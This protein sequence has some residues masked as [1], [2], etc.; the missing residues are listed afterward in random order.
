MKPKCLWCN[1]EMVP[2]KT[3][4]MLPLLLPP[5]HMFAKMLSNVNARGKWLQCPKCRWVAL[6]EKEPGEP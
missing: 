1:V 2:R 6:F 3:E 5:H 4:E